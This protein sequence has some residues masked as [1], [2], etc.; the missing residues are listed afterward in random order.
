LA[1][2]NSEGNAQIACSHHRNRSEAFRFQTKEIAVDSED[3][4]DFA[5]MAN[6][7]RSSRG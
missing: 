3:I 1:G 5:R 4:G 6:V 7:V 2:S